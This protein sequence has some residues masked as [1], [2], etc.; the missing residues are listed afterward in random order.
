MLKLVKLETRERVVTPCV[1][2]NFGWVGTVD[3]KIT[4]H[5]TN[6]TWRI[7]QNEDTKQTQTINIITKTL[8]RHG[9]G[10]VLP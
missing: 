10:V 2:L 8:T 4:I 9:H 3:Y 7:H 5:M 1:G 6:T